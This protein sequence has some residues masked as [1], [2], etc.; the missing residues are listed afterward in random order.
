MNDSGGILANKVLQMSRVFAHRNTSKECMGKRCYCVPGESLG[1][2]AGRVMQ[3][4][5]A[6]MTRFSGS[7]LRGGTTAPENLDLHWS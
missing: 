2:A 4:G 5:L 7:I 6:I 1:H 3:A